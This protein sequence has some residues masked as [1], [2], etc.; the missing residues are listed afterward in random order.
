MLACAPI[1]SRLLSSCLAAALLAVTACSSQVQGSSTG[2]TTTAGTGG[3]GAS[4]AGSGGSTSVTTGNGGDPGA[5][6]GGGS[7]VSTGGGGGDP[8]VD[9]SK[10]GTEQFPTF[11]KSCAADTDCVLKVHV[12]TCCGTH[13]IIGIAASESLAF[14]K[15]EAKCE[16]QLLGCGCNT[17]P[18]LTEDGKQTDYN[19]MNS[20]VA[21]QEGSCMSYT[22]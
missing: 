10:F 20:A 22:P 12:A 7:A 13:V 14:D 1:T 5:T 3:A 11:D 17:G 6:G 4:T 19:G 18:T 8:V 9:C 21:C 16:S 15:A 2:G